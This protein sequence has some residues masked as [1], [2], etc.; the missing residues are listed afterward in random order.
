MRCVPVS[1]V[2]PGWRSYVQ[3]VATSL[4][5]GERRARRRRRLLA[6]HGDHRLAHDLGALE[7]STVGTRRVGAARNDA[8]VGAE[9]RAGRR[10]ARLEHHHQVV[11]A[12][13]LRALHRAGAHA[14]AQIDST[15]YARS[16]TTYFRRRGAISASYASRSPTSARAFASSAV[17][18]RPGLKSSA[19]AGASTSRSVDV[20]FQRP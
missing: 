6:L 3:I 8:D 10:A 11:G 5:S 9:E 2:P 17:P 4:S 19:P 18:F 14:R 15:L 20:A 13:L 7:A 12:V 1:V 16:T